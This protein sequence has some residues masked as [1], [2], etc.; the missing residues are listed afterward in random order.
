MFSFFPPYNLHIFGCPWSS[1][2][3]VFFSSCREWR[4]LS[5]CGA[6]GSHCSQWLLLWT[7]ALGAG[8]VLWC[9]GL[10]ALQHL[11]S[12][13]I[14]V[15]NLCLLHWQSDSYPLDHQGS[16]QY[17]FL[18]HI[19][20]RAVLDITE[21]W[22]QFL[23]RLFSAGVNFLKSFKLCHVMWFLDPLIALISDPL[24]LIWLEESTLR[25]WPAVTLI[26]C[27]SEEG[28]NA[29]TCIDLVVK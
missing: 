9:R 25:S 13:W 29:M 12:F 18:F 17:M 7:Q 5:S 28:L 1:M 2:L 21:E 8:S 3:H 15:T 4:L 19:L 26:L 20:S 14:R 24:K 6:R 16:P 22:Y 10:V 27:I 11:E 23:H